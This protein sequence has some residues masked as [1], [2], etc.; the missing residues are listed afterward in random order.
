[1][2]KSYDRMK[3]VLTK[4]DL[5]DFENT[6][7]SFELKA[8]AS[9][10][11]E[12]NDQLFSMLDECFIDSANSYGLSM[13]EQIIGSIRTD[14]SL[15]ERRNMLKLREN[16]DMSSFT[17]DKIKEALSS[18]NLDCTL[19]EYPSLYKV[20]IVANGE[21]KAEQQAWIQTQVEKIMPA[22][23]EVYIVF[24]GMTFEQIDTKDNTYSFIDS[25]DYT[26]ADIEKLK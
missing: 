2:S 20:V 25:L 3:S 26:W 21:Y 18:F 7:V 22:H 11:D 6:T 5:Y 19:Y 13:R 8:Y 1:M 23:L 10:L 15:K 24:D 17:P 4:L 12:V 14:L 16:I 9:V